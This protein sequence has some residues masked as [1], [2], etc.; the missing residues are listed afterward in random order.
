[1]QRINK[2]HEKPNR[3]DKVYTLTMYINKPL[4]GRKTTSL[5]GKGDLIDTD[6]QAALS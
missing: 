3:S 6:V 5:E 4:P 1:M 2:V